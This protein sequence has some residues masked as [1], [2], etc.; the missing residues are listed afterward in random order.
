MKQ[1]IRV[2]LVGCGG[3]AQSQH[4]PGYLRTENVEIAALCD[5]N[6]TLLHR[7]AEQYSVTAWYSD[8]RELLALPDLDAVDI[9]TAPDSHFPIAL[10]AIKAGKHV[11][12]EKP[13]ALTYPEAKQLYDA[14]QA[15]GV[16]TG[17]GF[18]HRVTPAARLAHQLV[19]S[20]ALGEIYSVMAIFSAGGAN[21]AA[22]PMRWRNQQQVAGAGALFD[23]GSHMVDM[24]RWW[25]GQEI[26]TVSAQTRIFVPQRQWP[27]GAWATVD[28][29]DASTMMA[30]FAGG[31]MATFMNSFAATGRGFDQRVEL[32]GSNGALIY[33][34]ATP[35]EL[36]VCIGEEMLKLS[37]AAGFESRKKDPYPAMRVPEKLRDRWWTG[38][39][40]TRSLTPDFI[41]AIRGEEALLPTFYEGM[42]VQEVLD[43]ALLSVAQERWV[44]L[45]M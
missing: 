30:G 35:F 8:Y 28:T 7:V 36:A 2:G 11:F 3:I 27:N 20:G 14:A 6:A 12:C 39:G 32:Y 22:Q 17:I 43:A 40:S 9:C 1:M 29:D 44:R 45:P 34:Q 18:V 33:D 38:G 15:A 41:A 42:K 31:A 4:L 19:S 13:L 5:V 37:A 16:V 26:T 24:V 21:Y 23:L 25:L 10:A